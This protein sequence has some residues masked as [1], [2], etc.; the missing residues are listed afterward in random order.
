MLERHSD[1]GEPVSPPP[2]KNTG[3]G[4][5][6]PV[7]VYILV[8]FAVAFLLMIWS[9]ISHQRS[10]TEA[11]GRLQG[12]V[13][14]M[15]E[16]QELQEQVIQLQKELAEVKEQ[17]ELEQE[18]AET[19]AAA[20]RDEAGALLTERDSLEAQVAALTALYRLQQLYAARDLESCEAEIGALDSGSLL[21]SLDAV[22]RE[23]E[24]SVTPPSE[25]YLEL[26][27]AVRALEDR[28]P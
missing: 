4:G 7:I 10:N 6:K 19:A 14:A 25:R 12:S 28:A 5:K 24:W 21:D 23:R 26:K 3:S 9:L 22:S 20:A 2:E 13:S 11:I 15:Q 1:T 17:L 18:D 27:E 16:V 8:L